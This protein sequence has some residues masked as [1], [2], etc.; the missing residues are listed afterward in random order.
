MHVKRRLGLM[1]GAAVTIFVVV[2]ASSY[3]AVSSLIQQQSWLEHSREATAEFHRLLYQLAIVDS[4]EERYLLTGNQKFL[5]ERERN[6]KLTI[7]SINQLSDLDRDDVEQT[8]ILTQLR[9]LVAADTMEF[10]DTASIYQK[11]GLDVA[12]Q[13][14]E[15]SGKDK[16]NEQKFRDFETQFEANQA[17]LLRERSEMVM[18]AIKSTLMSLL[19]GGVLSVG[20]VGLFNFYFGRHI[21][22]A[23]QELVNAAENAE[24]GRVVIIKIDSDD[25]FAELGDAFNQLSLSQ[26]AANRSLKSWERDNLHLSEVRPMLG[27]LEQAN[28]V[29]S[30]VA[31][32]ATAVRVPVENAM[33]K[34][35]VVHRSTTEVRRLLATGNENLTSLKGSIE[36]CSEQAD[37]LGGL[38][39]ELDNI[40]NALEVI[41]MSVDMTAPDGQPVLGAVMT[42]LHELSDRCHR[43]RE[44]IGESLTRMQTLLSRAMLAT[45]AASGAESAAS[46]LLGGVTDSVEMLIQ[47][48]E[49]CRSAS[50][51]VIESVATQAELLAACRAISAKIAEHDADKGEVVKKL[52][53]SL[54]QTKAPS[55]P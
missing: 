2:T 10:R 28:S 27:P 44:T 8:S 40:S 42:R 46:Q 32:Y 30:I 4:D 16:T 19:A 50:A 39:S 55:S 47:E 51:M 35:S 31:E 17:K 5:D 13:M 7:A 23:I 25:E 22:N 52:Q 15:L 3:F 54:D 18:R 48:L 26:D 45:H 21:T 20:F 38:Q 6:M 24:H 14:Q 9:D 36:E 43:Q 34:G 33:S 11:Q 1:T 29:N 41:S 37:R 49:T 12:I 53:Q